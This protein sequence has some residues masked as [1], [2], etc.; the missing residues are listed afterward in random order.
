MAKKQL[1]RFKGKKAIP[2]KNLKNYLVDAIQPNTT[3]LDIGCGPKLYSS[4]FVEICSRVLTIDAWD[5]VDPDI[6]A[7]LEKSNIEDLV[8][9]EKFDYILMLDFIEHLSKSAGK[10]LIEDCKKICNK[11]IFLL[12]PL[13]EIWTDNHENVEN[14][15]Y[16][17]FGNSYDLH[18][19]IWCPEDFH[20]W[21]KI[22]IPGFENYYVGSYSCAK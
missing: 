17:C 8:N 4:P 20:E 10:K 6:L 16:W 18:K 5:H 12:T 21:E 2:N 15:D 9:N 1:H 7:D 19:S 14:E 11:K 3:L 13:E 22:I